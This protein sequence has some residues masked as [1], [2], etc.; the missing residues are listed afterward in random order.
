M[1][2]KSMKS[3][4]E[5]TVS[6]TGT[7]LSVLNFNDGKKSI[8][9]AKGKQAK[10]L[11]EVQLNELLDYIEKNKRHK[12]RDRV[13]VLL[14]FKAGLRVCEISN[15]KW[16]MI[17]DA[18]GNINW[19]IDLPN[20]AT[21]GKI[22]GREIPINSLLREALIDL[23]KV[24]HEVGETDPD[25]H[26]IYSQLGSRKSARVLTVWFHRLF[27]EELGFI[28]CSSHSGRRTFI[29]KAARAITT[30]GGSLRDVQLLAGHTTLN[31]TQR[32]IDG[33]KE[34]QSSVVNM[35]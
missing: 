10:V 9:M 15:L 22:G 31:T 34:A 35:I 30:A 7:D 17:L 4:R 29:T 32:Y 26:I 3:V 11:N 23:Y 6:V 12:E 28:G 16:K 19:F 27:K 2:M 5:S 24:R 1:L 14:S 21:K 33:N 18:T 25:D 8:T 13:I 20:I